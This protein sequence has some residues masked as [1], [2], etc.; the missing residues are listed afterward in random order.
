M[1]ARLK[2]IFFVSG[3]IILNIIMVFLP[4]LFPKNDN[5]RLIQY[6]YL[7]ILGAFIF[8]RVFVLKRNGQPINYRGLFYVL[9]IAIAALFIGKIVYQMMT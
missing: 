3:L 4:T 8:F 1:T 7:F 5:I 9:L 6:A 2:N